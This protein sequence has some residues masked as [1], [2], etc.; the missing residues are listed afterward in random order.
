MDSEEGA[1]AAA[2]LGANHRRVRPPMHHEPIYHMY[3]EC[4]P[5]NDEGAVGVEHIDVMYNRWAVQNPLLLRQRILER[6]GA[7]LL[8]KVLCF[9]S[10]L[11]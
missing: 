11:V 1:A 2:M 9:S 10:F 7:E 3:I 5:A 4:K 6:L 8:L